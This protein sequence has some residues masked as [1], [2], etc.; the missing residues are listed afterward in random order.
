MMAGM[1]PRVGK[2][3]PWPSV[4][5]RT[6]LVVTLLPQLGILWILHRPSPTRLPAALVAAATE[7]LLGEATLAVERATID[8][9]G[10]VRLD[11]LRIEH[12]PSGVV[13]LGEARV[14]PSWSGL[15]GWEDAPPRLAARGRLA[16]LRADGAGA[17]LAEDV[18]LRAGDPSGATLEL[19]TRIGG[20]RLRLASHTMALLP[21]RP[22]TAAR[23]GTTPDWRAWLREAGRLEGGAEVIAGEGIWQ[24]EVAVRAGDSPSGSWRLG[25]LEGWALDDMGDL[26][27]WARAEG[28][29]LGDLSAGVIRGH[30]WPGMASL[31]I[32]DGRWGTLEGVRAGGT[33]VA[34]RDATRARLALWAGDS[35]VRLRLSD[36]EGKAGWQVDRL[37]GVLRAPELLRLPGSAEALRRAGIDLAGGVELADATLEIASGAVT[38]AQGWFA[39]RDAGWKDI[40]PAIIRP[41]RPSAAL[42]GH[43][44][45]D[46]V[47]GSFAATQLDLAGLTG[48]IEGGLTAGS[49]YVVRLAS[50]PGNPVHPGCLDSLLGDW[51][52]DLWRRFD[53][54]TGGACPQAD[55]VVKGRWGSSVAEEVK[56]GATLERFGFMGARFVD[57]AVRVRATGTS[58]VVDIDQLTGELEGKAAGSARGTVTWDWTSG[59]GLPDIRAEGDLHPLVALRLQEGGA[60]HVGRL[61]GAVF[62][63]PYL[64][65]A[66]PAKGTTT[67]NL[68]TRGPSDILGAKFGP[69]NLDF[70]LDPRKPGMIHLTGA[71]D[72]AGGTVS[73]VLEGDF[74]TRNRVESLKVDGVRWAKL[75]QALPFLFSEQPEAE[76][77]DATLTGSF[78]GALDLGTHPTVE[79]QGDFVLR[80]SQLRRVQLFGVLTEGLDTLGLGFSGYDLTEARGEFQV[81]EG[82]VRLPRLV[83][84]G[85]DAELRLAGT[86]DL[87]SGGLKLAG[88]FQLKDSRWGPLGLLNPNRLITKVIKIKV[89]GTLAKPETK[90]GAGF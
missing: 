11:G 43:A 12:A 13:F 81:K 82:K 18:V 45:V 62:G 76:S 29:C 3:R 70:A 7:R 42:R 65:V 25:K 68:T 64:K 33:L 53:L 16:D 52:E 32:E 49:P 75:P 5:A 61:R 73:L 89:G 9:R 77:S 72:L 38:S 8:R 86:V 84:G 35:A 4:V 41:E 67:V 22:V 51:W 58:T 34:T 79:G 59:Q 31:A 1:S 24:A 80:D 39:I 26:V 50:T 55:V 6:A 21:K 23:A 78:A 2:R 28:V 57:T 63:E 47:A 46:I 83:I 14:S 17:T 37:A 60:A 44:R 20:V 74:G 30:A 56:V 87:N 71:G 48:S 66:I 85:E 19:A 36:P 40:R 69:L 54:T 88:D 90:V 27:G 15:L 10:E